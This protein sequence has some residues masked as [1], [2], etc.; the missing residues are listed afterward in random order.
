[1]ALFLFQAAYTSQALAALA[2]SSQD[3]SVAARDV[4]AR[5]GGKM[6]AFY[7]C[8]G[9][10]DVVAI[11]EAPDLTAATA[12]AIAVAAPGHLKATKT[13][14]LLT[15]AEGMAAFAKAGTITYS[16]PS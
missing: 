11:F 8:V 3:R 14:P 2:K 5:G 9:E 13:T 12:V 1:M 7:Y 10:Y 16:G 15:T 6:H 4:I